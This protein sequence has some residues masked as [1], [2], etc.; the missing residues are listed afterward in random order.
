[1]RA[2]A[3]TRELAA[4]LGADGAVVGA[5][6]LEERA[7]LIGARDDRDPLVVLGGGARHR[8]AAD[9]DRVDLG[10]LEERVEVRDDEVER[11]DAVRLEIGAVRFLAAVGEQPAV[12]LRVQRLH[13][14][15][16]HLGR[17]R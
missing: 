6:L 10:S 14:M 3:S 13:P 17:R 16:E 2:N 15:V 12:D 7:V 1:M 5:Q 11:L 4:G 9:V 8:R